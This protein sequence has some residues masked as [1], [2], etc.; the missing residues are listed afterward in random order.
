VAAGGIVGWSS[1]RAL[2][3]LEN[4]SVS[5]GTDE[6]P[7]QFNGSGWDGGG[8][9]M[10]GRTADWGSVRVVGGSVNITVAASGTFGGILGHTRAGGC[11][12]EVSGGT[13]VSVRFATSTGD[14]QGGILGRAVDSSANNTASRSGNTFAAITT[15]VNRPAGVY[16]SDVTVTTTFVGAPGGQHLGGIVGGA[17]NSRVEITDSS[18]TITHRSGTAHHG[19]GGILSELNV[20]A[21]PN[22]GL[23][24]TN[25]TVNLTFTHV[26][27]VGT[28]DA[29]LW[30]GAVGS[31]AGT[32]SNAAITVVN[33]GNTITVTVNRQDESTV[34]ITDGTFRTGL[35]A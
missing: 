11:R 7:L 15:N 22:Q 28:G 19:R 16:I 13:V 17:L 32:N 29:P 18:V 20:G 34:T 10:V 30:E 24:I 1:N 27:N 8:G 6:A 2:V 26:P 12:L 21:G 5:G 9:G 25:N 3:L 35:P 31:I 14:W 4:V 23:L 33:T